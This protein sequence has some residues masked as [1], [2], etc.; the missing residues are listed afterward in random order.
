MAKTKHDIMK[1]ASEIVHYNSAGIP[2]YVKSDSLS[3]YPEMRAL[4]H[5]HDDLE[6]IRIRDGGMYYKIGHQAVLLKEGDCLAVN[7]RQIH[8][9]YSS[10]GKECHFLCILV[11]P[12]LFSANRT[13]YDRYIRPFIENEQ[14]GFLYFPAEPGAGTADAEISA[15]ISSLLE[16]TASLRE[17]QAP[18]Y[19]LE[20]IGIMHLL[21]GRLISHGLLCPSAGTEQALSR[22][23]TDTDAQR[24]MVSYIFQNYSGKLTL[25]DIAAAGHVSRS[26]CCRIFR[27]CLQQTPI[28]FLNQY[29]LQVSRRLLEDGLSVTEAATVCGFGHLSYFSKLFRECFGCTPTEYRRG[30]QSPVSEYGVNCNQMCAGI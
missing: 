16:Q 12:Q 21:L 23:N 15:E 24:A 26:K 2:L 27:N 29:R 13:L 20:I 10:A 7:S 5:W 8:Y 4:C 11:H 19:E 22:S 1:D 28:D 14:I 6:F 30:S 3:E 17:K 18:G 9:G 25:D